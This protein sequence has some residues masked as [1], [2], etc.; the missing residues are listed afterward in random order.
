LAA[1]GLFSM[2]LGG[3]PLAPGGGSVRMGAGAYAEPGVVTMLRRKWSPFAG[4]ACGAVLGFAVVVLFV[5]VVAA[6]SV[7]LSY[8]SIG[9]V[10]DL[11]ILLSVL[12]TA[13]GAAVGFGVG[14]SIVKKTEQDRR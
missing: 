1:L 6:S 8:G 3:F 10:I 7:G 9:P 13:G 2:G 12:G 11:I 4:L 14:R 5:Q